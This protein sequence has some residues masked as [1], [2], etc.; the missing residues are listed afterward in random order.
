M[1]QIELFKEK[2]NCCACS[3]CV[4]ACPKGAISMQEDE[5]GFKYPVIDRKSCVECGA[6]KRVC[7]FQNV[8]EK[9]VPIK[10]YAA[11][12]GNIDNNASASGGIF[13]SIAKQVLLEGGY[14]YGA[15]LEYS[16]GRLCPM[17]IEINKLEN[18]IKLQ[19]SKYV[20][21]DVG[22]TYS[23]AKQRLSEGKK[24]LFSGTPC[25]VAGLK[26]YLGKRE[27]DDLLTIDIICHGVPS[28]KLFEEYIG[29]LE[30]KYKGKIKKFYFRDKTYGSGYNTKLVY[31]T[32]KGKEREAYFPSW[33][34]SFYSYFLQ[35]EICRENCYECKYTCRNRPGDFTIGDFW[36]YD[37][38]K[39]KIPTNITHLF[40]EKKGI[41]CLI[42]NTT[43]GI[44]FLEN[45][46]DNIVMVEVNYSDV[47]ENNEQLKHPS[48]YGEKRDWIFSSYLQYGY[49]Y[50]DDHFNKEL[51]NSRIKSKIKRILACILK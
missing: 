8:E 2:K 4:N 26:A 32:K 23:M 39:L 10:S 13:A 18:L 15:S 27:H 28:A 19:G 21:S 16:D 22:N 40:D 48:I 41:S 9:N 47:E 33:Q 44:A 20:Q 45:N 51:D 35:S 6:C 7:A 31:E 30:K 38:E 14:V 50:I 43:K 29:I 1:S 12:A 24:V 25:Q 42:A 5:R 17:H 11:V 49:K 3:A 36:G 34:S 37:A 46:P